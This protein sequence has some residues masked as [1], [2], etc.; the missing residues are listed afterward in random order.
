M[1]ALR[2]TVCLIVVS[3]AFSLSSSIREGFGEEVNDRMLA[4]WT[5]F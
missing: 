3:G 4:L 5:P 2:I 1:F